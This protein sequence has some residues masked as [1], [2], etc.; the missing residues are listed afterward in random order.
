MESIA[1]VMSNIQDLSASAPVLFDKANPDWGGVAEVLR[2][3]GVAPES[4]CAATWCSLG[5]RNIEALIDA[6]QL[7]LVHSG[8]IICTVGKKKMLGGGMKYDSINF[9]QVRAIAPAEYTD[10][11]GLGKF[12]IEFGAAGGMLLGR[13]QWRWQG[14]RFRKNQQ[15]IVAVAEERDRILGVV[16]SI[17]G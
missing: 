12:C 1:G 5:H 4:V 16:S 11:R 7:T 13:L 10:D 14:K 8:G 17:V 9:A 15:D 3:T 2:V 6:P